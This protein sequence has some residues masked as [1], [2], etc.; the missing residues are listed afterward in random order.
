MKKIE[1]LS[2]S[3]INLFYRDI[4]EFYMKY[5]SD[6]RPP[7]FPQTPAMAVGSSFDAY[8]KSYLH[9]KLFGKGADPKYELIT[10]FEAQVQPHCRDEAWKAGKY[11]MECY[12]ETGA[13]SDLMLELSGALGTPQFEIE[14]KGVVEGHREG[15]TKDVQGVILL[16]KPDVFFV[17][18]YACPIVLDFKVNGYY[19]NYKVTPMKGYLKLR[20]TNTLQ[21][22]QHK[23]CLGMIHKGMLINVAHHLE[24]LNKEWAI[25][26]AVYAWLS[27]VSVGEDFIVAI[28]QLACDGTIKPWP[29]IRIAEHRM[30]IK[31]N[32]QYLMFSQIQHVWEVVNSDHIFRN[33][34]KEESQAQCEVLDQVS[35]DYSNP[36]SNNDDWFNKRIR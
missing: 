24:D 26:L 23:D 2:P 3:R 33:M 31:Q 7:E 35:L 29:D 32:H 15:I 25:Q 19:S 27:G 20:N 1:Y 12:K 14:L 34:S 13:L 5:L 11:C 9:E 18:K 8:V 30:K 21:T 36:T 28:D 4:K 10:L 17:N 6:N 16:G 22:V